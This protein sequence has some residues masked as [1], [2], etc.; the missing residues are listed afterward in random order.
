MNTHR[1]HAVSFY[2]SVSDQSRSFLLLM[3]MT[4]KGRVH[5]R[6]SLTK[7][8][9]RHV[10]RYV[11]T[12]VIRVWTAAAAVLIVVAEMV[13]EGEAEDALETRGP[14]GSASL[15]FLLSC[16]HPSLRKA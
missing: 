1:L 12:V 9:G 6:S 13:K 10:E 8:M 11:S 7:I 3:E 2:G 15:C 5:G 4:A 16:M 14:T